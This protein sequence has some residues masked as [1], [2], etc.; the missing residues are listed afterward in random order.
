MNAKLK[1]WL[2]FFRLPNLPSAAGDALAGVAIASYI[3]SVQTKPLAVIAAALGSLLLYMWGLADNDITD[4]ERDKT[5]APH[6]PIPSGRITLARAKLARLLCILPILPLSYLAVTP[7]LWLAAAAAI[8]LAVLTYNRIKERLPIL[9]T[10]V[11]GSCRGF[12]MLSGI[13]AVTTLPLVTSASQ[14]AILI[15]VLCVWTLQTAS[16]TIIA[17]NEDKAEKPLSPLRYLPALLPLIPAAMLILIPSQQSPLTLIPLTAISLLSSIRWI[18][19][20]RPL[21]FNHTPLIRRKTIGKLITTLFYLQGAYA[22][23]LNPITAPLFAL[24]IVAKIIITRKAKKI[25]A[26]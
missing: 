5:E 24:C 6:R 13:A 2:E 26:S 16:L 8:I 21:G 9:G 22:L 15:A 1:P 14:T 25:L 3:F 12:S 7:T 23:T 20:V 11:M 10:L 19:A 17:L 18:T 4:S